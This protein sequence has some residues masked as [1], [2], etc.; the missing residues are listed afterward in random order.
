MPENSNTPDLELASLEDIS[1]ELKGRY[2]SFII[3][4]KNP[5]GTNDKTT[6]HETVCFGPVDTLIG[7]CEITKQKLLADF[8]NA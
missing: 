4:V 1:E 3:V 2:D 5:P 7:M 8:L 6:C